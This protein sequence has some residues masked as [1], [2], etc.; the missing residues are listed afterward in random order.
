VVLLFPG[1]ESAPEELRNSRKEER[2]SNDACLF[3]PVRTTLQRLSIGAL[4]R[5]AS[6]TKLLSSDAADFMTNICSRKLAKPSQF[7]ATRK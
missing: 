3:K 2:R 5:R 6:S 1:K 7:Y 4:Q